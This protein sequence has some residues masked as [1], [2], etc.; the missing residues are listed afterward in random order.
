VLIPQT[1]FVLLA[2]LKA[3]A[4]PAADTSW[5]KHVIDPGTVPAVTP[6]E[7]GLVDHIIAVNKAK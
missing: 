4:A 5:V 1:I 7:S 6:A 3:P 2:N